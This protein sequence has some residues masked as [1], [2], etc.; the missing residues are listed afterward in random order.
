MDPPRKR[1]CLLPALVG[2]LVLAACGG[3]DG[4]TPFGEPTTGA[5][6]DE[7]NSPT[8]SATGDSVSTD[9]GP[10]D[11]GVEI[12]ENCE[13]PATE[14]AVG[15]SVE[16]EIVGGDQPPLQRLFY[17][18]VVPPGATEVSFELGGMT[19]DLDLF[20]AYGALETV[21]SGGVAFWSSS[22]RGLDDEGVVIEPGVVRGELGG[23]EQL[24][25]VTPGAYYI[26]V[27]GIGFNESS[28]FKLTVTAS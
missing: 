21:Q 8:D 4:P 13:S 2:V 5:D 26:E 18:V 15:A 25:A 16:D 11:F 20:V 9:A 6:A 14:I 24:E 3:S 22:T 19:A 17:C 27:S 1:L 12:V 23:F 7:L 10:S 28:P